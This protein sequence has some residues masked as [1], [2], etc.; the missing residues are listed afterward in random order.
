MA[1]IINQKNEDF[2]EILLIAPD[3]TLGEHRKHLNKKSLEKVTQE[4]HKDYT[5]TPISEISDLF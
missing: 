5:H 2:D 4:I 1:E 3:K